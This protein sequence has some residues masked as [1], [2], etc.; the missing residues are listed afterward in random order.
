METIRKNLLLIIAVAV[1]VYSVCSDM[2]AAVYAVSCAVEDAPFLRG[3]RINKDNPFDIEFILDPAGKQEVTQDECAKLVRYFLA[4]LALSDEKLW[5][6]L[7]PDEK[8][9]IIDDTVAQ[10]EIGDTLLEQ[11]YLLKQVASSLTHP[12]TPAGR[13][14]WSIENRQST[15]ENR[16]ELSKIWIKPGDVSICDEDNMV[17]IVDV[18]LDVESETAFSRILLPEIKRIVNQGRDFA[19]LRQM[20]HSLIVAQWFK[21]KFADYLF[22]F[23]YNAGNVSGIDKGNPLLKEDVFKRYAESFARG[24]YDVVRKERDPYSGRLAKRRYFNGGVDAVLD[25]SRLSVVDMSSALDTVG[26]EY[27]LFSINARFMSESAAIQS[28]SITPEKALTI[29]N[30]LDKEKTMEGFIRSASMLV[31]ESSLG[32]SNAANLQ[33]DVKA[34]GV[35][36][37]ALDGLYNAGLVSIQEIFSISGNLG[38][39]VDRANLAVFLEGLFAGRYDNNLDNI[40][41]ECKEYMDKAVKDAVYIAGVIRRKRAEAVAFQRPLDTSAIRAVRRW[42]DSLDRLERKDIL[43]AVVLYRRV[44]VPLRNACTVRFRQIDNIDDF[45]ALS[46]FVLNSGIMKGKDIQIAV[47]SE[48]RN[49]AGAAHVLDTGLI[50]TYGA[51]LPE[52]WRQWSANNVSSHAP[53]ITLS[54]YTQEMLDIHQ[55][56]NEYFEQEQI[57]SEIRNAVMKIEISIAET[58]ANWYTRMVIIDDLFKLSGSYTGKEVEKAAYTDKNKDSFKIHRVALEIMEMLKRNGFDGER[59]DDLLVCYGAADDFVRDKRIDIAAE[60]LFEHISR[61]ELDNS[62][63]PIINSLIKLVPDLSRATEKLAELLPGFEDKLLSYQYDPAEME[64]VLECLVQK[65][66]AAQNISSA[67]YVSDTQENGGINIGSMLGSS[68]KP[69]IFLPGARTSQKKEN[70]VLTFRFRGKPQRKKAGEIL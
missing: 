4:G 41:D 37:E 49:K 31:G 25:R 26:S 69:D 43:E 5:V 23:Y 18:E 34:V 30:S 12:D 50:T 32:I 16:E 20:V 62:P 46:M 19:P 53:E 15:I 17:F 63:L 39:S 67:V 59:L 3:V 2:P 66:D 42:L 29:I 54:E 38:D 28:S 70:A 57:G 11:D 58:Y 8:D 10:T 22:S 27:G 56:L 36:S 64:R 14:Y 60:E 51:R 68:V 55:W 21:L 44:S 40:P 52:T 6:N 48:I 61:L 45:A 1:F 24:S 47:P 9:R 7:S 33:E 13:A 65:I 35:I